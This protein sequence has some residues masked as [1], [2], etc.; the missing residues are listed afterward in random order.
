MPQAGEFMEI[1]IVSS[2]W[3]TQKILLPRFKFGLCVLF[4]YGPKD[5]KYARIILCR[6]SLLS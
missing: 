1:A 5:N 6:L 4:I 3:L 2:T